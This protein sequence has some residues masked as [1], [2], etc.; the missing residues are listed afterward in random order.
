MIHLVVIKCHSG[1][2]YLKYTFHYY[3]Y[4]EA[5]VESELE[6]DLL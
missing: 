2:I 1:L 3:W 6:L 5:G 4:L